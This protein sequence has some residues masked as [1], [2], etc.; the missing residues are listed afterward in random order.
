[1]SDVADDHRYRR[2][3]RMADDGTPMAC[4]AAALDRAG[5][6][7]SSS[8]WCR[9]MTVRVL[10]SQ[11]G[12]L[13]DSRDRAE[14]ADDIDAPAGR[15]AWLRDDPPEWG[16]YIE[17]AC[18][19]VDHLADLSRRSGSEFLVVAVPAPWQIAAQASNGPGVREAAGVPAD[20]LYSSNR[21]FE[22]L[23]EYLSERDIGFVNVAASF[24]AAPEPAGLYLANAPRLSAVGHALYARL[25]ADVLFERL[26]A[27]RP[28]A[29][30]A[31]FGR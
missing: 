14:D 8:G 4:T 6:A 19:A 9:L 29:T 28:P 25:L 7:E 30:T 3:V 5:T 10:K 26:P 1:M 31:Q 24:R 16:T 13:T 17:Q 12:L 2:D 15:Y 11:F 20:A 23:S 22:Q 18:S 27:F 21:P